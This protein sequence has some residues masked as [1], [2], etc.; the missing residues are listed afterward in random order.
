MSLET[1][2][3]CQHII[4]S[5]ID[6]CPHCGLRFRETVARRLIRYAVGAVLVLAVI[7]AVV[8]AVIYWLPGGAVDSPG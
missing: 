6:A 7:A 4:Q 2:P 5:D 8:G 1:C 3:E